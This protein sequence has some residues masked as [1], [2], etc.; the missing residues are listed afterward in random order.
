MR[1]LI[2]RVLNASVT[3]DG[4]VI[5]S[6]EKGMLLFVC[7]EKG[8]SEESL[9]KCVEKISKL[10]IFDDENGRLHF[11]ITEAG[12]KILS[13]SQ[14]TLSWDGTGGHRPSFENSENP[15]LAR[16]RY[17]LLNKMFRDQGLEVSEGRFGADMKVSLVNDGP[18]TFM[19]QF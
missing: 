9:H 17:A 12:G 19:L 16:L 8:D 14:F 13:V 5:S 6:I 15:Q 2:Q 1:V 18:V 7:F 11:N 4:E 3:V 10:R